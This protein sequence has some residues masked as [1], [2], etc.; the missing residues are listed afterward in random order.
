MDAPAAASPGGL[1]PGRVLDQLLDAEQR[2]AQPQVGPDALLHAGD[3][4]DVPFEALGAVRG[5]DADRLPLGRL[6][7]ERVPGDLLGGD[8]VDE[9][10]GPRLRKPVDEPGGVVEQ[11]HDGVEVAVRGRA[12]RPA[13]GALLQQHVG[14]AALLPHGPQHVLGGAAFAARCAAPRR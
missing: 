13:L 14:L 5:E 7:G 11:R 8:G 1:R 3:H 10:L 12:A 6:L 9:Q 2:P 4:D